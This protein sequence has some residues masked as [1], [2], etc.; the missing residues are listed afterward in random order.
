MKNGLE[1]KK[2]KKVNSDAERAEIDFLLTVFFQRLEHWPDDSF[3][4]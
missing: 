4:K 1:K 3:N 2:T